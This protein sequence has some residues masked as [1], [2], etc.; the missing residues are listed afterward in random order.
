MTQAGAPY[1]ALAD[2][3]I[4]IFLLMIALAAA[5]AL[6]APYAKR[7]AVHLAMKRRYRRRALRQERIHKRHATLY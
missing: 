1:Y 7:L 6:L 2:Q 3:L 4:P 5:C